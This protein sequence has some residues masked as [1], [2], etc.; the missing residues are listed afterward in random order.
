MAKL[1][2]HD[3]VKVI[4]GKAKGK[5]GKIL[6]I[7]KAEGLALVEGANVGKKHQKPTQKDQKGGIV[8]RELPIHL[9]NLMLVGKGGA[10]VKVAVRAVEGKR[11]RVE[12]KTGKAVE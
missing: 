10:P 12:K 8:D 3:V 7:L 11:T 1:K 9:S 5:T 2:K 4:A 6:Q